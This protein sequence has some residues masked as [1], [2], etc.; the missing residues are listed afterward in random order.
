MV[1]AIAFALCLLCDEVELV[2]GEI[3][4]D[5]KVTEE[6]E[7]YR[8][9]KGAGSR[10]VLKSEVVRV[11]PGD[12]LDEQYVKR[13][14]A[15][16]PDD[17]AGRLDLARWC[18][19]KKLGDRAAE[20]Y[21]GIIAINPDHEEARAALGYRRHNGEW[22]T[23]DQVKEALGLVRHKGKWMTPEQRDLEIALEAK[24]EIEKKYSFEVDKWL[25]RLGSSDAAK[26]AE[27]KE[28]LAPLAD[29]AKLRRFVDEIRSSKDQVRLYVIQ[30]LG[31]MAA[32]VQAAG[33]KLVEKAGKEL[34]RKAIWDPQQEIRDAAVKTVEKIDP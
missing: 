6:G 23:E 2:S 3:I 29:S 8:I 24:R 7:H 14:G 28:K 15:L 22:M 12:T 30:E 19:A 21:R 5:C 1:I 34:A 20:Q 17:I 33:E 9:Q 31:R 27:A 25:D 18:A 13:A 16:K 11:T 32:D 4:R 10:L 26:V